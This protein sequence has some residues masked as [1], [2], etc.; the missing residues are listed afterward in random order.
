MPALRVPLNRKD[1]V[2]IKIAPH[3]NDV[4]KLPS[5]ISLAFTDIHFRT[6]AYSASE[7]GSVTGWRPMK[8]P[9]MP[10]ATYS[11]ILSGCQLNR[12]PS[13]RLGPAPSPAA[14][15]S[16]D[17]PPSL[18][19]S[20]FSSPGRLDHNLHEIPYSKKLV[21]V[22]THPDAGSETAEDDS[23]MHPGAQRRLRPAKRALTEMQLEP[24]PNS[25]ED[26]IEVHVDERKQG[27]TSA[28]RR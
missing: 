2:V 22:Q 5:H 7:P 11:S 1:W 19:P 20:S 12:K 13:L 25:D 10:E 24:L 3:G 17:A 8:P 21:P 14:R 16:L 23:H 18:P 26:T 6:L 15:L 27:Q 28:Q 9:A 4:W